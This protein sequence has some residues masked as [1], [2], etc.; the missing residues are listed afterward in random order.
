MVEVKVLMPVAVFIIMTSVV[1]AASPGVPADK[2]QTR[3]VLQKLIDCDLVSIDVRLG[4]VILAGDYT[5]QFQLVSGQK[6]EDAGRIS[7]LAVGDQTF[8]ESVAISETAAILHPSVGEN[9]LRDKLHKFFGG[10]NWH[11][12]DRTISATRKDVI[13]QRETRE[14]RQD[15]KLVIQYSFG[16]W[17]PTLLF[18]IKVINWPM[19]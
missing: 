18:G 15:K 1:A 16:D 13:V 17:T 9:W 6:D 4:A 3:S 12:G 7:A 10:E 14:T 2:D 5:G 11:L 8:L 19:M